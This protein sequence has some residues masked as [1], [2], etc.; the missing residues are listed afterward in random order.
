MAR[1]REPRR[2]KGPAFK[3]SAQVEAGTRHLLSGAGGVASATLTYFGGEA[4]FK[5]IGFISQANEAGLFSESGGLSVAEGIKAVALG[6]S[7]FK[8]GAWSVRMHNV[9]R[10]VETGRRSSKKSS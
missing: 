9:A 2:G 8:T 7:A 5:A 4:V 6:Y 3:V 1:D 10:A